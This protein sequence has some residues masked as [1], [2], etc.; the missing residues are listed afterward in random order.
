MI[1]AEGNSTLYYPTGVNSNHVTR[2][3]TETR[4][5]ET[6][7][8]LSFHPRC[9]VARNGWICCG[10]ENG[11]FAV[12]RD[13][14]QTN[15]NEPMASSASSNSGNSNA[16]AHISGTTNVDDAL[17][18]NFQSHLRS[19]ESPPGSDSAALTSSFSRDMFNFLEQRL[20]GPT[21]TWTATNHK[22]GS[23]RVNC[24]T[25]WEP[26]KAT[27]LFQARPGHYATP[28]AV[29][30]NND[31]TVTIVGLHDCEY[32]DELE[33]QDGVNRSII[34][35]DGTLLASISD[36]PFLYLHTRKA[37]N[38]GKMGEF[39]EWKSLPRVRVENPPKNNPNDCRGS[40][41][42]SFSASGRYL[43]VGVQNGTILVFNVAALQNAD[44][45]PLVASFL[46][47]RHPDIH[48]AIR[49]M[50]F[51]PGPYDLLAWTEHRGRIGLADARTNF[52]Q[53][54]IISLDQPDDYDHLSLNDRSTIDP[55][56]LEHR[57][58][59]NTTSGTSSHLA[60][61]F[62]QASSTSQTGS[63]QP[64]ANAESPAEATE[65]LNHPFTP[66]ETAILEA[67]S[68]ERRRREAR[69]SRDQTSQDMPGSG[70]VW[71]S[72]LWADRVS[73]PPLS[74]TLVSSLERLQS[75]LQ[76]LDRSAPTTSDGERDD[77]AL[78][79]RQQREALHRLL[80]RD[81]RVRR[82]G[83]E[84]PH[85]PAGSQNQTTSEQERDRRAPTPRRSSIMQALTSD[86]GP[87]SAWTRA[88]NNE[89][90][91]I[92]D[93]PTPWVA[94]RASSGWADLE[95]LYNISGGDGNG[96]TDNIRVQPPRTRRAIPVPVIN[97]VWN[98]DLSGFGTRRGYPRLSSRDHTQHPDD[99]AGL[100]W[101]DDGQTL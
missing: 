61:L 96:S 39:Y 58:D 63:P 68:N 90:A 64:P 40:F 27:S 22:Y 84:P 49:D 20:N 32:L 79:L 6:V 89:T 7:K 42:A 24:I 14:E 77:I 80:S 78:T 52:T 71:R 31:K 51:C 55:R 76:S 53:R 46:S 98:D 30:A 5:S 86:S 74:S 35:P 95:A 28:V 21:K 41:A 88:Q 56:L 37:V 45:E 72:P 60:R 19:L 66:E 93:S 13:V 87:A 94:G 23:E 85:R 4:E 70:S 62:S 8:I 73:P 11:E 9:L 33:L 26:P 100:T 65:R 44:P 17:S 25:I 82:D 3:N 48:A 92:R 67:V 91:N 47:S 69:E 34:S 29:L 101:S 54:Q 50:A 36:D 2:L 10:G 15:G 83:A 18:S 57:S 1:S 81:T 16:N 43:A 12:I 75:A 99:T 59:R 97:D 38:K